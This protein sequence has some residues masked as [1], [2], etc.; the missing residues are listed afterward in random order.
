MRPAR[1]IGSIS[2]MNI[3]DLARLI[4]NIV[5]LGTIA[6]VQMQPPRVKVSSGNITT[7]WLPW[8]NL[9]AGADREWDPPTIGEQVVLLSPSGNLTQGVAL[10]GLF[11]DLITANGDR[12]GLHRRTYRDGAVIEYD[13]IA[14]HLRAT[15][16]GTAEVTAV[17]DISIT[18]G[19]QIQIAA[20]GDVVITGANVRIN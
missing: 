10:T 4:E 11:S 5:R 15:L 2:G 6:E 13:S 20:A 9:R 7:T 18:S 12:E 17:G 8:L 16:P 1:A 3:A 19:G 14:K